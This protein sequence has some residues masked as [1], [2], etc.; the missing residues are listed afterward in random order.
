LLPF[1]LEVRRLEDKSLFQKVVIFTAAVQQVKHDITWEVR[2][3]ETTQVQYNILEYLFV[4]QQ[5]T[6]GEISDCIH[7]SP[8]NTSRE[9]KKL[10]EKQL[11]EKKIDHDDRRRQTIELSL[12]GRKLM[13]NA[14][15]IV[16]QRFDDRLQTVEEE[17]IS[18][19]IQAI[20]LLQG[21]LFY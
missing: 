12:K 8:P 19:L 6:A 7:I 9:L 11:I 3:A 15:T 2:P 18:E 16:K 20:Q 4:K 21:K 17:E 10:E 14:F 1:L 5:A 13:D